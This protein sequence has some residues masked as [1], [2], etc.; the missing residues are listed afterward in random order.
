MK[1][2][3]LCPSCTHFLVYLLQLS[4]DGEADYDTIIGMLPEVLADRGGKMISKCKH[5]S[6]YQ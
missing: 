2:S 5:V 4:A 1:I 6:E 3:S